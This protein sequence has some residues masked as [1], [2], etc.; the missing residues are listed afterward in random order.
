LRVGLRSRLFDVREIPFGMREMGFGMGTSGFDMRQ[1]AFGVRCARGQPP[2]RSAYQF[3]QFVG[4]SPRGRMRDFPFG[5]RI[6]CRIINLMN[7]EYFLELL[8]KQPFVPFVIR[9]SSGE[10]H[11]VR[12]PECAA[13]TKTRIVVA[14]LEADRITVCALLHV[15]SVDVLQSAA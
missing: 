12:H 3:W 5:G 7:Q 14:D 2:M 15:A 6:R 8:R 1:I 11:I 4:T 13:L 10:T 9:L